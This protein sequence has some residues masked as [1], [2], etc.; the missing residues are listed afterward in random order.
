MFVFYGYC[1][2]EEYMKPKFTLENVDLATCCTEADKHTN[3]W[4]WYSGVITYVYD[5]TERVCKLYGIA[6]TLDY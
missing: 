2:P 5:P 4:R 1:L 6:G 3:D